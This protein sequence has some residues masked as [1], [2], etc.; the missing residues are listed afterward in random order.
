MSDRTVQ[1][2]PL[3]NDQFAA[4][5]GTDHGRVVGF[6]TKGDN[7]GVTL[8]TP[9]AMAALHLLDLDPTVASYNVTPFLV[10]V[11]DAKGIVEYVPD[12][13]VTDVAGGVWLLGVRD[14]GRA[15]PGTGIPHQS[16]VE[17]LASMSRTFV[18]MEPDPV[19]ASTAGYVHS[20][21][22]QQWWSYPDGF[23]EEVVSV[24]DELGGEATFR[25]VTRELVSR[26]WP[27]HAPEVW[28]A[29]TEARRES[30][31]TTKVDNYVASAVILAAAKGLID[32]DP[33]SR[34]ALDDRLYPARTF[35]REHSVGLMAADDCL[36][37]DAKA[38]RDMSE[39]AIEIFK[40]LNP[41]NDGR[42][43]GF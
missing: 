25:S 40:G 32:Y 23:F 2:I 12:F 30:P 35:L 29:F 17:A 34:G 22:R 39:N 36:C 26:G 41:E 8:A 33:R 27:A 11:R 16:V 21:A 38:V 37:G 28:N 43:Y 9:A 18:C 42:S 20:R 10:R 7:K 31:T 14:L 5:L 24:T 15:A 13:E 4:R 3:S 1:I 6:G 19:I